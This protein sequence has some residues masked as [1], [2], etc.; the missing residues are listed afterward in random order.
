MK[1]SQKY[2]V[3][4]AL[5]YFSS[6]NRRVF[7]YSD[8][9]IAVHKAEVNTIPKAMKNQLYDVRRRCA[10]NAGRSASLVD[11]TVVA[12]LVHAATPAIIGAMMSTRMTSVS[13]QE[14]VEFCESSD[15][16]KQERS[17]DGG[18]RVVAALRK[19]FGRYC[20]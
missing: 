20:R 1:T 17:C 19:S 15:V 3:E 9:V 11:L 8:A 14:D 6:A 18:A 5:Y 13:K 2:K 7:R 12:L 16:R 10:C 4:V